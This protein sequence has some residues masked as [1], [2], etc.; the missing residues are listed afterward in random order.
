MTHILAEKESLCGGAVDAIDLLFLLF[1]FFT[2]Y[3]LLFGKILLGL[4]VT[5]TWWPKE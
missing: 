2:N 1:L 5:L 4:D 3:Y